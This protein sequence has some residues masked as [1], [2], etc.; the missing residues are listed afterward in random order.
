MDV[1]PEQAR[2]ALASIEKITRQTRKAIAESG[3][4]RMLIIWGI[5]WVI[6][7]IGTHYWQNTGYEGLLWMVL[8]ITGAVLTY[9]N[10][11]KTS[12]RV[13]QAGESRLGYFWLAIIL[14]AALF[15]LIQPTIDPRQVVMV[16]VLMS[17]LGYVLM[18]IWLKASVIGWTGVVTTAASLI[19]YL[20][21]SE[22]FF[23]LMALF[24][25][26]TLIGA[27]LYISRKWK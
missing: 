15:L 1:S 2:E 13:R 18:G 22:I 14:Y 19:S 12:Q 17:M 25:G 11:R 8:N 5:I 10:A 7:F 21:F 23:L 3:G 9:L 27:G 20:L 6:G 26:G 24:G 16:F 4:G